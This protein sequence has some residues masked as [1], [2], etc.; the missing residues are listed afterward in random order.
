[1]AGEFPRGLYQAFAMLEHMPVEQRH[2]LVAQLVEKYPSHAPAWALHAQF[3]KNPS[4]AL[5]AI[6][7]GLAARP[8]PDTRGSL[9]VQ[10]AL[11]LHAQGASERALEILEPLTA[12]TGDSVATHAKARVAVA[13]VQSAAS[14]RQQP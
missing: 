2:S 3:L 10:K 7:R 9:L 12:S 8:D 11:V 4:D 14:S 13:F 1:M 5:A 6:E